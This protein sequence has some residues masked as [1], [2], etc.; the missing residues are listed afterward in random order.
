MKKLKI[1][2]LILCIFSSI[3]LAGCGDVELEAATIVRDDART[4]GSLSFVYDKNQRMIYFGGTEEVVQYSGADESRGMEEGCRVGLRVTAPNESLDLETAT[5]EMNG[6]HYSSSQ[7]L[8]NING[9]PQRFFSIYP[10]VN[11][12]DEEIMFKVKW[13]DGT[14]EQEYKIVVVKGT[15]FM[16]KDGEIE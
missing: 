2:L 1:G 9:Q 16:N 10:I 12:E 7:F 6:I 13:S 8:E 5:L 14:K 15:K 4:G 11:K 3:C